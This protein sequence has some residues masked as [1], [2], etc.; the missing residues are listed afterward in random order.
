MNKLTIWFKPESMEGNDEQTFDCIDMSIQNGFLV[1]YLIPDFE[2]NKTVLGWNIDTIDSWRFIQFPKGDEED[3][4]ISE[5][6]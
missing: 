1:V 6:Q 3:E 2:D 5:E 4:G